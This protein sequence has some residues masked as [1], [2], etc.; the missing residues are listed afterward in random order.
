MSL[1]VSVPRLDDVSLYELF[2]AIISRAVDGTRLPFFVD[3]QNQRVGV[4]TSTPR[5]ATKMDV[6]GGDVGISDAG[7][8]LNVKTPDGTKTYRIYIDNDG[9]VSSVRLTALALCFLALPAS[10]QVGSSNTYL[11]RQATQTVTADKLYTVLHSSEIG[12]RSDSNGVNFSSRV[13]VNG[14]L[15][16]TGS[17]IPSTAPA[18]LAL[19]AQLP[20]TQTW[21]GAN[22]FVGQSSFN[23]RVDFNAETNI[24][25]VLVASGTFTTTSTMTISFAE[26]SAGLYRLAVGVIKDGSTAQ[27]LLRFNNDPG[28]NYDTSQRAI[29]SDGVGTDD[30]GT[31][32][33]SCYIGRSGVNLLASGTAMGSW[34]FM[35]NPDNTKTIVGAGTVN[36]QSASNTWYATIT[37]CKYTGN[38]TITSANVTTGTGDMT[39]YM[40]L[41][42]VQ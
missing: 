7:A 25:Q 27:V 5:S 30:S 34:T 12:G 37:G 1:S 32:T 28:A 36:H 16:V 29:G 26:L 18:S 3:E 15:I 33:T 9:L 13:V 20:A 11:S 22:R 23:A 8:G 17:I 6:A 35:V 2:R 21:T 10:A 42:R 41:V 4:G 39:G 38:V 14:D 31:D 24:G 19:Y 40:H